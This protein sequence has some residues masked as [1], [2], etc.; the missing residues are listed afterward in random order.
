MADIFREIDEEVRRDKALEAWKKHGNKVIGL[1][2]VAVLATA[3]WRVYDFYATKQAQE[4]GARFETALEASRDGRTEEAERELAAIAKDGSKG[5]QTLAR[6]REA[7]EIAKSKPDEAVK[8]YDAIAADASYPATLRDVARLRAAL[9]LVDTAGPAD[10]KAR[11]DPLLS[12]PFAAN[13]REL[14][15]LASL[16]A[17]D[18]DGAGRYLDEIIV[19]RAAPSSLRQR[20]DLLMAIVRAGPVKPA[21]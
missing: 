7:A 5:Y 2:L 1:A 10:M 3:G 13:A 8:T 11:L 21:N 15:A 14:L 12:G 6:V 9:L 16:K 19:D 17:G 18:L 4:A 20:A